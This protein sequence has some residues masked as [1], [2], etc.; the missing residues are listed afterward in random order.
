MSDMLKHSVIGP[1]KV[2][3]FVEE[4]SPGFPNGYAPV[5]NTFRVIPPVSNQLN[6]FEEVYF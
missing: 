6:I 4:M 3:F 1:Y 5:Y 2:Y